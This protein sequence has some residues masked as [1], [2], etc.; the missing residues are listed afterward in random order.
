MRSSELQGV[1]AHEV[2][3]KSAQKE[4]LCQGLGPGKAT[5]VQDPA[6][7]LR[8]HA[9]AQEGHEGILVLGAEGR[10]KERQKVRT[11]LLGTLS[12]GRDWMQSRFQR[13]QAWYLETVAQDSGWAGAGPNAGAV[14]S[15]PCRPAAEL[16]PGRAGL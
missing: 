1:E 15:A 4:T 7:E 16:H 13:E 14:T 11:V 6:E 9:G 3:R 12:K 5:G 2:I 10:A 8:R